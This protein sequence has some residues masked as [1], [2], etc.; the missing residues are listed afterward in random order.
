MTDLVVRRLLIDLETPVARHWNG[1]D[2]FRTAFFNALSFSF[3]AGEQF[4][5]DSVRRVLDSAEPELRLQFAEQTRA[6]I[7]QEATH[8]RIHERFNA[9]LERQGLI[10]HWDAR[11]RRRQKLIDGADPRAWL[12]FTAATEH[13]TAFLADHL[14]T[15]AEVLQGAEPRLHDLWLW[16]ASEESE[17]RCVAF[18]LYRASGG[19]E[20]WRRR[21]FWMVTLTFAS[22]LMRQTLN[23]LWHDGTWWRASTWVSAWRML[24]GRGGLLHACFR[25][26]R[27]YLRADFHPSQTDDRLGRQWLSAHVD[28]APPVARESGR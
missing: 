12:G 22:D 6:F 10:N 23:N 21:L 28:L 26:W 24:L 25:P 27:R 15:H 18:D 1:G 7:G 14:L 20:A 9:H 5:I 19:G 16:H 3:P 8:R 11:I 13:F 2:A 4:F 17:H